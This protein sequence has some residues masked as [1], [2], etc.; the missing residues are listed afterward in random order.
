LVNLPFCQ[1]KR[2]ALLKKK[3]HWVRE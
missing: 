3:L 2:L 1:A